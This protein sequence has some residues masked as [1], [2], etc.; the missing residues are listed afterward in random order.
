ME[1]LHGQA[2]TRTARS[3]ITQAAISLV[4]VLP[5]IILE[6]INRQNLQTDFP[7]ALFAVLWLLSFSFI[8][9]LLP[10]ARRL[11]NRNLTSPLA[12]V[13]KVVLLAVI[14]SIMIVLLVDQMPCFLGV[15][16]CD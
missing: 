2:R 15:P 3:L 16:N 1:D 4:V 11:R 14:A 12:V 9:L 7:V 8:L 10:L 6:L 13:P 5:F